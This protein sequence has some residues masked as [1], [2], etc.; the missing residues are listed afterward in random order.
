MARE[1]KNNSHCVHISRILSSQHVVR[2]NLFVK[3]KS[4]CKTCTASDFHKNGI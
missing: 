3:K 4:A 2:S 1:E